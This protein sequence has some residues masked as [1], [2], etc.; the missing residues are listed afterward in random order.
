M[1]PACV[2]GLRGLDH[3]GFTVPDLEQATRFFVDVLG[4]RAMIDMGPF[5]SD[6]DWLRTNLDVHPRSVMK[7]W[8]YFRC[9]HGSNFEIFEYEAP[10]QNTTPPANSDIGGHHLAFYVDDIQAA[11]EH[12]RDRGVRLLGDIKH[13]ASG[14]N[15]GLSWIYFVT[16]W[17]M[18]CELVSYPH[19]RGYERTTHER[20][21]DPRD[22]AR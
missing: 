9:G 3:V 22:P 18:Y 15:Q 17:G 2:P 12:L 7:R 20:L 5:Q 19:G 4:C 6:D 11:V 13:R 14:P 21:W 16:P 1:D 8:R 10:G